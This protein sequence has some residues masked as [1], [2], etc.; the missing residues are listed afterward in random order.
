MINIDS[1]TK[2][3]GV[4]GY[5][6]EHSYSPQIH[7]YISE[8]M[9]L[10]YIYTSMKVSPADLKAAID[11][12]KSLGFTGVN[13]TVPHKT[14]VIKHLDSVDDAALEYGSVNTVKVKNKKLIGYSTDALGYFKSLTDTGFDIKGK[15]VL[16]IGAGG[17]AR[18]IC[19]KLINKGAKSISV[20]NRT[21]E[22]TIRLCDYVQKTCGFKINDT[23]ILSR[24]DL[25]I[26]TTPVGMYPNTEASPLDDFS[27]IDKDTLVSDLIYNPG[28]T[29]FLKRAK[30]RGAK[31]I[32][33]LG[34]LIYQAM[35][36][37]EIFTDT[38]LDFSLYNEIV[39]NV[40]KETV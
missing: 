16:I 14:E 21:K 26:N 8:K 3:L 39:E 28:E 5:P 22:N 29:L 38:K 18:P 37:Y 2:L 13:V 36:S 31:I 17:A 25:V 32:N 10:N 1:K 4:I 35:Y 27:F 12:V 6:I 15:D 20:K 19:I 7:N 34:M 24:Y 23:P 9:G 40:F 30:N 33:G 11:G